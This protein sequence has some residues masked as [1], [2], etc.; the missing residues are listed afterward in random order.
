MDIGLANLNGKSAGKIG[1][2]TIGY[3]ICTTLVATI[4]GIILAILIRP[5]HVINNDV[6]TVKSV[7]DTPSLSARDVFLDLVRNIFPDNIVQATFAMSGTVYVKLDTQTAIQNEHINGKNSSNNDTD[8]TEDEAWTPTSVYKPGMNALGKVLSVE[9]LTSTT[10]QLA[11]YLTTIIAGTSL[12]V[13]ILLPLLYFA[14]TKKNP[15]RIIRGVTQ[16]IVTALAIASSSATLPVTIRCC[17]ENLKMNNAITRFVLP[18]G[19]TINMDGIPNAAIVTLMVILSS[20]GLPIESISILLAVDW[21]LYVSYNPGPFL[22]CT[23]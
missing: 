4:V 5:G 7:D 17:E 19:A 13:L 6:I 22:V 12:H 21:F 3:Y 8:T 10:Q 9:D 16:A 14:L 23:F 1:L 18:L 15:F 20:V 11:I 2:I